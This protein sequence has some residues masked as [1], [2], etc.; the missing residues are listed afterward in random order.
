[1]L[2]LNGQILNVL[3]V[4][5]FKDKKTGEVTPARF[6]V[7]LMGQTITQ[8]G[9]VKIE[10]VNLTVADAEPYKALKGCDVVVPVGVFVTG[11]AAV[12]HATKGGV[13]MAA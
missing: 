12:Y 11:G 7:Q 4:P 10:L 2:T 1:M 13:P 8:Q 9:E 3:S 6:R 5:E